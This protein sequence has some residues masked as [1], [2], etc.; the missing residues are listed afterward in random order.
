MNE[1]DIE[2]VIG[3][4]QVDLEP[5]KGIFESGQMKT[6]MA[7][8][9]KEIQIVNL[10]GRK[11]SWFLKKVDQT[12]E[13][14]RLR[15]WGNGITNR[16]DGVI[17]QF[18]NKRPIPEYQIK[19]N[20]QLSRIDAKVSSMYLTQVIR[21]FS[22]FK[23]FLDSTNAKFL[24]TT[25]T[26]SYVNLENLL[27]AI[28]TFPLSKVNGGSEVKFSDFIFYSGANRILSRDVVTILVENFKNLDY[29]FLNDVAIGD[30]LFKYHFQHVDISSMTF[31]NIEEIQGTDPEIIKKTVH[32]RLK[33][34]SM[35]K[36]NDPELMHL[37][38]KIINS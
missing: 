14:L 16:I 18:L 33:S 26:S 2:V 23:Y 7:N 17:S 27:N 13:F 25:N 1:P 19:S 20:D 3:L 9:P 10:Y 5:W 32:F 24:Y 29:R 11:P 36:R 35:H 28:N 38:H 31:A 21:E 34:G 4:T 37:I 12:H 6:W 15:P 30:L 22:L 8:C